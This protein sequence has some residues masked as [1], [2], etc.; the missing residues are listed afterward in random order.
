MAESVFKVNLRK[1]GSSGIEVSEIGFGAWG[2][3]GYTPGLPAYGET[4]DAESEKALQAAYDSGITFFDTS[5]LYGL[6]HSEELIGKAL[7]AVRSKICIATKGGFR[8]IQESQDFS[9][10]YIRSALDASLR[11]LGTDYVDLYQLHSPSLDV[12]EPVLEL[13]KS[14]EELKRE[15][16]IRALGISVRSPNDGLLATPWGFDS[17]QVNFNM[18]DQR[19]LTNGLFEAALKHKTGI[20]VRTPLSYGFLTGEFSERENFGSADHR[21]RCS[22]EQR[23]LWAQAGKLFFNSFETHQTPAQAALRFCLSFP[24]VTTVI[25][26]ILK[27]KQ[28]QEN[29]AASMLGPL[30]DKDLSR[31]REIYASNTFFVPKI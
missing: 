18:T 4:D 14:L 19:A 22:Q 28:A 3:G 25:P 12:A 8:G 2:I 29:A 31:I 23:R 17:I 11:R 13:K 5:D 15:G 26:G 30:S 27:A 6:G 16:K 24:A 9:P 20:I 10:K 21:S 1:L 7:K